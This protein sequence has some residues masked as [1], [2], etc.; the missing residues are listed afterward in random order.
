MGKGKKPKCPNDR[1]SHMTTCKWGGIW[2]FWL[3]VVILPGK[4]F[5][6]YII[7]SRGEFYSFSVQQ[8]LLLRPIWY[9]STATGHHA[10]A[11]E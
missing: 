10:V 6:I 7:T 9:E 3:Q 4:S 2:L 5:H 11:G 1:K 8:L